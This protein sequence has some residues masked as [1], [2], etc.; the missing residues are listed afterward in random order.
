M[1]YGDPRGAKDA[2]ALEEET[3]T[4]TVGEK[5][6]SVA[7]GTDPDLGP[8]IE[9]LDGTVGEKGASVA[10][11]TDPD[12]GPG[13]EELDGTVGEKGASVAV[14]TDPDLGPGIEEL[15]GTVNAIAPGNSSTRE[16]ARGH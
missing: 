9:E 15:D 12:L 10:V 13:I 1:E 7:V 3:G 5:G 11:G 4:G 8:G 14:G 16:A 6:A 2:V